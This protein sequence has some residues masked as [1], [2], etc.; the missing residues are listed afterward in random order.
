MDLMDS[1]TKITTKED[2]IMFLKLFY[3]DVARN[4]GKWENLDLV[5]FLFAMERFLSSSTE[6]S[7]VVI[8]FKPTWELFAKILITSAIYE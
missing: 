4:K 5:D 8:D 2:F 7:L 6:K 3:E 1:A